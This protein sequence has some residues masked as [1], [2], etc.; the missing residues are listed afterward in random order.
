MAKKREKFT[1]QQV[2]LAIDNATAI[3][4][5]YFIKQGREQQQRPLLLRERM[6]LS[7]CLPAT[8]SPSVTL[9]CSGYLMSC[10]EKRTPP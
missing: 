9:F 6:F 3:L 8:V 7:L 1:S 5:Y 4:G 10:G 2:S